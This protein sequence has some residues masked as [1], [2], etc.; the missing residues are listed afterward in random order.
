MGKILSAFVTQTNTPIISVVKQ[1]DESITS[2]NTMSNDAE[3]KGEL[4]TPNHSYRFLLVLYFNSHADPSLKYQLSI[5]SGAAEHNESADW[6]GQTAQD[7]TDAT[8][9]TAV[10]TNATNQSIVTHGFINITTKGE[11]AVQ[12]AQGFNDVNTTTVLKGSSFT[13]WS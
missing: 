8:D 12:W 2:D 6:N 7:I 1:I 4:N 9:S 13:V 11:L 3:L 5:P 10:T